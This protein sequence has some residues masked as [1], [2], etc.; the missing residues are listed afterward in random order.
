[1]TPDA[2]QALFA[3]VARGETTPE[4]AL[5]SLKS[6]PYQ[7]LGYACLDHHRQLRQGSPEVVYAEFKTP[8]EVVTI[9]QALVNQGANLLCTRLQPEAMTALHQALP[10]TTLHERS[11]LGIL[12]QEPQT[13]PGKVA[14]VCA[15]TSDIPVAEE[16]RLTLEFYGIQTYHRY[17]VGVAGLHRLLSIQDDLQ[18]CDT[19]IVV[20]GMEGALASVVAGLVASPVIAVPTSVGYGANLEGITTLLSLVNSCAAGVTVVN[21]DNGFGAANSAF[22]TVQRITR[23]A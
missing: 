10:Q 20:A 7:D 21:I 6:F 9:S 3:R 4:A 11:R 13:L 16:A 2:L 8:D 22:R 19:I 5:A 23:S 14:V 18:D 1:M 15:G 17:D 12:I